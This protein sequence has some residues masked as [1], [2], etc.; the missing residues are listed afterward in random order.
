MLLLLLVFL[1]YV[2]ISIKVP[3]NMPSSNRPRKLLS[4]E[5]SLRR[6]SSQVYGGYYTC[7]MVKLKAQDQDF[8]VMVDT[9]STDTIFPSKT[10][11]DYKVGPHI[12]FPIDPNITT[13]YAAYGDGSFWHGYII[14]ESVFLSGTDVNA[15][16]P[17]VLMKN[18]STNPLF[19][20]GN[21]QQGLLGLGFRELSTAQ[22]SPYS[23]MDSWYESGALN[24]NEIGF[25]GCP[26]QREEE[27]YI[28]FGNELTF[29][30]CSNK[31]ATIN[32]PV[33]SYYNVD[34][35]SIKVNNIKSKLPEDFQNTGY[36]YYSIL[37]SCTSLIT[38]PSSVVL[39]LQQAMLSSGGLSP[40]L[41]SSDSFKSWFDGEIALFLGSTYLDF[42]RLPDITIQLA[43]NRTDYKD[44]SLTLGPRQYIQIDSDGYYEMM[45]VGSNDYYA[46][47][48]LP[49]FSSYHIV[50]DRNNGSI[51]FTSGCA[52]EAAVDGYPKILVDG[53]TI[54]GF[55]NTVRHN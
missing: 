5:L 12:T 17:I 11:N 35:Q 48:G 13:D 20:S 1:A 41:T 18:Q 30:G 44:V 14:R 32:I 53:E 42:D 55:R 22:N 10:T 28:D 15:T 16:A 43:S 26:Y 21:P 45:I 50:L 23:V 52:C 29:K 37:D 36:M 6:T 33:M 31:S 51:T 24:K 27:S 2:S 8:L 46:I 38:L 49:I 7:F 54:I 19:I 3:V 4:G 25:H 34:I 40:R 9:G 47:L 39:D